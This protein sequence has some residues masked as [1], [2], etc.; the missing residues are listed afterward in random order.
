MEDE[1]ESASGSLHLNMHTPLTQQSQSGLT[2]FVPRHSVGTYPEK[3]SHTTCQGTFSSVISA[4]WAT[5]DWYWPKE[6]NDCE[7]ISTLKK[8][9][10][11]GDNGQ[12]FSQNPRK[13]GKSHRHS[14]DGFFWSSLHPCQ[15]LNDLKSFIL[16]IR[17]DCD[18]T[19]TWYCAC[20]N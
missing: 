3:S 13:R 19:T 20:R 6:W 16:F 15:I 18:Y 8:K 7:L 5:V 4:R 17:L 2:M 9:S 1:E 11:G 10:A 12:T 14:T